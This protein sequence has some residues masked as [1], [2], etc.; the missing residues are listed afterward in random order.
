[1]KFIAAVMVD[2]TESPLGTRSRLAEAIDGVPVLRRCLARLTRAQRIDGVFVVASPTD[3]PGLAP[4]IEGLRVLVE[5]AHLQ[6]GPFSELVRAGRWWGLD[7]WR[8]GVGSLCVFDEDINLPMLAALVRKH[9]ADAVVCVPAAAALIDPVLTDAMIAH[10]ETLGHELNFTFTQAPPGLAPIILGRRLLEE[11]APSNEPV[12]LLLAYNPDRPV[13]DLTGKEACYRA[14]AAVIEAGGRL[15]CDTA[16]SVERVRELIEAGAD[17]WTAERTGRHLGERAGSHALA[18]P[19]EIE[20]ELTTKRATAGAS[21]IR[22]TG[23]D[24][25]Q[26]GP[27]SLEVIR[28]IIDGIRN[29]DD[30]RIVLGGFGEP[31]LHPSFSEICRMLRPTAAALAVRTYAEC[32]NTDA[33]D[34]LFE[35]PVEV[36]EIPLDAT[37]AETYRTVHGVDAFAE[38]IARVERWLE[39]RVKAGRARPLVAPSF[40]KCIENVNEMEAFFDNWQ[41]RLG[42]SLITGHSDYAGQ[43]P[44]HAVTRTDPP[45]RGACRRVRSRM[46]ILADGSVTTC[47][48]DYRGLQVAGRLT[49]LPLSEVWHS[50]MLERVRRNEIGAMPLCKACREW[51]RP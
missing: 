44:S 46:T 39:R 15:L 31:L 26:R 43:R 42:M 36:V 41:R 23:D 20:I 12:G 29:V 14:P 21:L 47:D 7:G 40:A 45:A 30:V 8:G 49:E 32:D 16:R 4:M 13:A 18:L 50:A 2:L 27:I 51:H 37:T 25:P 5:T 28:R 22:P 17:D 19:T 10:Y 33:E 11:L 3:A 34:A 48:Q 6:P 38:V 24:V 1:M 35:T 9:E